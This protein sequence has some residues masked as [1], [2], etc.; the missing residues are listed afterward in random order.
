[1]II[2]PDKRPKYIAYISTVLDAAGAENAAEKAQ[3]IFDLE[4]RM[5]EVHWEPAKRRNRD[6]T[7]NKKSIDELVAFAPEFPWVAS[8]EA[9]GLGDQTE[10]VVREDDAIAALAE[11][12][13]GNA[14]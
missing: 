10:F 9:A 8:F 5:A 13:R 7:Y 6:L 2:L 11:N 4:T 1:M 12:L 3:G 14:S